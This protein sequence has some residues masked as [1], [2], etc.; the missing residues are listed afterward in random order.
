MSSFAEDDVLGVYV[1]VPFCRGKCTF[2]NF[3]SDAFGSAQ[4]G[5]YVERLCAEV[6]R[7]RAEAERMGAVLPE[8]VD[9]VYLG[10]GTPSLL[11]GEQM[12]LVFAALR[13]EFAV[14]AGAEV[15]VECA[16][17]QI[18]P[19]VLEAMLGCGVNRASL[20]VQSFVDAESRA[21]GRGHT[22][23]VCEAEIARLRAAGVSEISVDLIAGL[24][25][26]T[27]ASWAESLAAVLGSGVPHASVY[28]L[29]VDGES[30]LGREAMDGGVRYGAGTLPADDEA[31]EFYGEACARFGA[32]GLR[33]YEISNFAREGHRAGYSEG[34][35]AGYTEGPPQGHRSRHN[36]KYWR[37]EPYVGFGLDA[38]SMLR[39]VGGG[40]LRF[41]NGDEL[42]PY[43]ADKD[44]GAGGALMV[45]GTGRVG[46]EVERIGLEAAF[47]ERLFLGLRMNDGVEVAALRRE[48]GAG[49]VEGG[50]AAV[51]EMDEAG[52]L[53]VVDGWLRLTGAGRLVSNEVF[54]RLLVDAPAAA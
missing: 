35:W 16:P 9:T 47:E 17:G 33:Q 20:G 21:V 5:P 10:G 8:R 41:A 45:L 32:A 25:G 19:E 46:R 52:L 54:E 48:F 27:A 24:P 3:A 34:Y 31:V 30:R 37:R 28:L 49:L 11:S 40:E 53:E 14:S 2:C 4:M 50:M 15:T 43:L 44:S 7:A 26:Q 39:A 6:R 23:A 12:R 38:H 51:G 13:G 42:A 36:V 18:A 29:E 22:R 1:S